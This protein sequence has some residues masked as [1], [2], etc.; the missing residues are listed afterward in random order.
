VVRAFFV[1]F[2]FSFQELVDMST[3][4]SL[5]LRRESSV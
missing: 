1:I 5:F 2:Y 3:A 4:K